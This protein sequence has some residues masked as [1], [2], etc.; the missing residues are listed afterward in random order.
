MRLQNE[1]FYRP[2]T[3]QHMISNITSLIAV[4]FADGQDLLDKCVLARVDIPLLQQHLEEKEGRAETYLVKEENS[5]FSRFKYPKRRYEWL[6][7]RIA[8]K[9]AAIQLSSPTRT[10]LTKNEWQSLKISQNNQ[11]KPSLC[12]LENRPNLPH[13][14]ISHSKG[15]AVGLASYSPCGVDI[16]EITAALERV[17]KRFVTQEEKDLLSAY[18]HA[19]VKRSDLGVIWSAKEA[20]KKASPLQPLPGFLEISLQELRGENG[21]QLGLLFKRDKNK[22][23]LHHRVFAIIY[24]KFSLALTFNESD[25]C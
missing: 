8:A 11:G 2:V 18:N 21:H 25:P 19:K 20:I 16:Q 12:S 23:K 1:P 14:S 7:G 4:S 15:V 3:I 9:Y 24:D 13:V 17:E 10:E 22:I 5:Q 6:G